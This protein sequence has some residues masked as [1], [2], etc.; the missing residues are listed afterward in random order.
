[1]RTTPID[2]IKD[3]T[4]KGWWGETTLTSIF[5]QAVSG[6]PHNL[7]LVDPSN[8]VDI[9]HGVAKRFTFA[10]LANRVE[11]LAA[12]LHA[13]GIGQEDMVVIQLPNIV[14]LVMLYLA[15]ARLGA[16]VSTVPVQ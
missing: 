9:T 14:E 1:M 16:I 15:L 2:R 10:E 11:N 7:A 4:D 8:R 5:D 12:I 3:F 13:R 6:R